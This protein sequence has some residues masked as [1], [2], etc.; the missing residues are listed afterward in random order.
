MKPLKEIPL[1][2]E[3][4]SDTRWRTSTVA[5]HAQAVERVIM[6]MRERY[7]DRLTLQDMAEIAFL[8]PFHF[9]RVFQRSTGLPPCR[10]LAALRIEAARRL[11]L[12]TQFSVTDVCFEVGYTSIGTFTTQF[13]EIAGLS[14]RRL[15]QLARETTVTGVEAWCA[16]VCSQSKGSDSPT[17]TGHICGPHLPASYIFVGLFSTPVPQ[18]QPIRCVLLTSP[19]SFQITNVP[20]GIYHIFAAAFP[21]SECPLSYLLP[22]IDSL[23]VGV[24]TKPLRIRAHQN[25]GDA[26][27]SLRPVHLT[28]PPIL[29]TLPFLLARHTSEVEAIVRG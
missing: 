2:P 15:R 4:L 12:T 24:A 29:V 23:H 26:D 25:S 11:L 19:D 18:G 21:R 6:T 22:D 1:S 14:P 17:I 28:D 20:D 9:S 13:T 3:L 16:N 8:S 5:E 7:A 10:F 27:V